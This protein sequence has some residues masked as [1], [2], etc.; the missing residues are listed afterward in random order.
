MILPYQMIKRR[1]L[2]EDLITPWTESGVSQGMTFGLGPAGYDA[3]IAQ[4]VYIPAHGFVLASTVEHFEIPNDLLPQVVDKSSWAR[5]GLA[6]QNTVAEPGWRGY[7]TLELT[8]Y[9]DEYIHILKHSPICQIIFH[10][11]AE[12]TQKPYSGKYQDQGQ[13][14]VPSIFEG[15]R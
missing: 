5:M 1:C 12:P 13:G 7:L 9:T 11:L 3:R 10:V 14:P 6:V 4:S 15:D 8:N 2:E